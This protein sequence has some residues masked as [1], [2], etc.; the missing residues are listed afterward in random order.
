[1]ARV[2]ELEQVKRLAAANLAEDD[3]VGPV[4]QGSLEKIPNRD[5]WQPVLRLPRF[6][7]DK[8][9][10]LQLNFRRVFDEENSLVVPNEFAEDVEQGRFSCPGAAADKDVFTGANVA[11]ELLSESLV[12][13]RGRD[14]CRG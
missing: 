14:P 3:S 11:F 10:L 4:T 8:V 6:K 9:R 5:G 2:E 1:M 13:R 12:E 7:P